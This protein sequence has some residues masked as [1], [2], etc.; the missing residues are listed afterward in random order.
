ML[1]RLCV[2]LTLGI[3]AMVALAQGAAADP[4]NAKDS[5]VF[6][7][8]CDG[9]RYCSS[10]PGSGTSHLPT[11]WAARRSWS[12]SLLTSRSSSLRQGGRP[13]P[14]RSSGPSPTRTARC[15]AAPT[16]PKPPR[17]APSTSLGWPPASS[18]RRHSNISKHKPCL[19]SERLRRLSGGVSFRGPRG[20]DLTPEIGPADMRVLTAQRARSATPPCSMP[21]RRTAA[22][23]PRPRRSWYGTTWSRSTRGCGSRGCGRSTPRTRPCASATASRF[24]GAGA[25]VQAAGG[26]EGLSR[27][28]RLQ[29]DWQEQPALE[30]SRCAADLTNHVDTGTRLLRSM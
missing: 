12:R 26:T 13:R 14:R 23:S 29:C 18:R 16:S 5:F 2:A 9:R 25:L 28:L 10:S 1:R 27:T 22:A 4:I 19:R 7:G 30:A 24:T 17:R 11:S 3:L 21:A 20:S 6:P 15:A 8:T